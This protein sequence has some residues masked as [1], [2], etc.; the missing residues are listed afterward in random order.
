MRLS[1][2]PSKKKPPLYSKLGIPQCVPLTFKAGD[3]EVRLE[4]AAPSWLRVKLLVSHF[5]LQVHFPSN[6]SEGITVTLCH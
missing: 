4:S 6:D 3:G 2:F 1:Q 5:M